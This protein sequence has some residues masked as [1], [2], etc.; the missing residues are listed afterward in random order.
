MD[1]YSSLTFPQYEIEVNIL[2]VWEPC[3]DQ[4]HNIIIRPT[5][6]N[7]LDYIIGS[8][9]VS[10]QYPSG[11]YSQVQNCG[12]VTVTLTDYDTEIVTTSVLMEEIL[13]QTDDLTKAG[14]TTTLVFRVSLDEFPNTT[15]WP[16][17]Q[18]SINLKEDDAENDQISKEIL[19]K[20]FQPAYL[21]NLGHL[22]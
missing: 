17:Y 22:S 1:N 16:E 7:V 10:L 8:G 5:E 2:P 15:S 3:T 13:V 18:I 19:K 12:A 11:F 6:E 9:Q 4:S 14:I 20:L 21:E